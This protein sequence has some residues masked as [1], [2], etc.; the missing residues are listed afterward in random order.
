MCYTELLKFA[1]SGH[2]GYIIKYIIK[3]V[4]NSDC[5]IVLWLGKAVIRIFGVISKLMRNKFSYNYLISIDISS[6]N[7]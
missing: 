1:Q 2:T 6:C 5:L 4:L 3:L 7:S